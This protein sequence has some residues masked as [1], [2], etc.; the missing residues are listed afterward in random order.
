MTERQGCSLQMPPAPFSLAELTSLLLQARS[1]VR[2]Q[3]RQS[4]M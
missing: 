3:P 4:S 1:L 2:T